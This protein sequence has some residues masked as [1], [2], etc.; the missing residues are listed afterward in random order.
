MCASQ[1]AQRIGENVGCVGTPCRHACGPAEIETTGN[2]ELRQTDRLVDAVMD[3]EVGWVQLCNRAVAA[4]DAVETK[5]H[6]VDK[7]WAE[8]MG[9]V[10]GEDVPLGRVEVAEAWN[11]V[12]WPVWFDDVSAVHRVVTMQPVPIRKIMADIRGPLAGVDRCGDRAAESCSSSRV[13]EIRARNPLDQFAHHRVGCR[14]AL[15]VAED[16]TI[17]VKI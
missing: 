15:G 6:F 2:G 12:A 10:Q 9:L 16:Q 5:T 3:T 17:D 7:T 1:L 4:S 8:D 11:R 13:R 14:S